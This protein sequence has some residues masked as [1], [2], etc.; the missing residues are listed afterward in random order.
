[1][2]GLFEES[3]RF[4]SYKLLKKKYSGIGTGLSYGAGHG[5]IESILLVG[6]TMISNLVLCIMLNTGNAEFFTKNVTGDALTRLNAQ[7]NALSTVN[8]AMFLVAGMERIFAVGIQ[9]SLAVIVYYSVYRK[10][11][12]YLYPLAVIIH[13][14]TDVPAL[15]AQTGIIKHIAVVEICAGIS[16]VVLIVLAK[17]VHEKLKEV[18]PA[19][20]LPHTAA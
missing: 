11:K 12:L 9:I 8:P 16:A 1:M 4:I 5:G 3:A 18:N 2:A 13:A 14:L 20:P 10:D 19:S 6:M 7:I 15:L 17:T